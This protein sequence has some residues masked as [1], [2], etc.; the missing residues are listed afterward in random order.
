[1]YTSLKNPARIETELDPRGIARLTIHNEA[2]LNTL[3]SALMDEFIVAVGELA[4]D[5]TLRAGS[6]DGRREQG[7]HRWRGY[8]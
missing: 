7:L 3:N 6:A 4:K 5:E 8:P 2:K 1:M